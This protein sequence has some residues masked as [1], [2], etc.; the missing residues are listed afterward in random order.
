MDCVAAYP[1]IYAFVRTDCE[2][3]RG[4]DELKERIQT[5]LGHMEQVRMPFPSTWF[6][7][8]RHLES[9]GNDFVSYDFFQQL[10]EEKGVLNNADLQMLSY[11]LHCLGNCTQLSRCTPERNNCSK[12]RMGHSRYIR[13]SQFP[14]CLRNDKV[15]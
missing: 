1:Q 9:V 11:V 13:N 2:D 10:C 7:V 8:K 5:A 15:R 3:G 6:A 4:L 14:Q 12:A